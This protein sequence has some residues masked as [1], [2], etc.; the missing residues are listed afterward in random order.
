MNL[1]LYLL[2]ISIS[3]ARH[4]AVTRPCPSSTGLKRAR[5]QHIARLVSEP[6]FDS[7][8]LRSRIWS[9]AHAAAYG[10]L[11][12]HQAFASQ[13]LPLLKR[14]AV[15]IERGLIV[16]QAISISPEFGDVQR[17]EIKELSELFFALPDLLLGA[18]R[19]WMSSPVAYQRVSCRSSSRSG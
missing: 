8:G 14:H 5:N 10:V 13:R 17:C 9:A 18:L 3:V 11:R 15:I 1:L 4:T 6:R 19:S 2:P 16:V 7:Y 12:M